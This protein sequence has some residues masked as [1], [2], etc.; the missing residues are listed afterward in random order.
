MSHAPD[1]R[2]DPGAPELDRRVA[3]QRRREAL[4]T[5][6]ALLR[7]Q[8]ADDAQVLQGPLA[9]ADRVRAGWR[10]VRA[11]VTWVAGGAALVAALRPRRSARLVMRVFWA[12]NAWRRA[13]RVLG[14]LV[15][16][17]L[18]ASGPHGSPRRPGSARRPAG[19]RG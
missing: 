4:L 3:L 16:T 13:Q 1:G 9:V 17:G 18:A 15:A 8:L 5:R 10:W 6:S 11:H 14:P 2:V 19:R 7:R 12:W